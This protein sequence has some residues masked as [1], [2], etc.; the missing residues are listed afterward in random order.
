MILKGCVPMLV[1][2]AM[3]IAMAPPLVSAQTVFGVE[4]VASAPTIVFSS[5]TYKSC[6]LR[7]VGLPINYERPVFP[8]LAWDINMA[9]HMADGTAVGV[10][11][12]SATQL[13]SLEEMR[14]AK[15]RAARVASTWIQKEGSEPLKGIGT[16]FNSDD[17]LSSLTPYPPV[18]IARYLADAATRT[19]DL[20]F[21]LGLQLAGESVTRIF[22][23]S[24]EVSKEDG[25]TY[26]Q[27][28]TALLKQKEAALPG[29]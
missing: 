25:M 23:F 14:A 16:P 17:G 11:K 21:L 4:G 26:M 24:P 1:A 19:R 12:A 29:R 27:C 10:L 22:R 20:H 8:I 15:G 2:G 28:I 13:N 7:L 18:E 5:G 9:I 3:A 6:G